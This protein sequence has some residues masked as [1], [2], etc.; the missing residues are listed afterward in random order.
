M[1]LRGPKCWAFAFIQDVCST[2]TFL[3]SP[4]FQLPLNLSFI[5][6]FFLCSE[7]S[8]ERPR[9]NTLLLCKMWTMC[10]NYLLGVQLQ[11]P[12]EG[13]A[14]PRGRR[15]LSRFFF[16]LVFPKAKPRRCVCNG[17]FYWLLAGRVFLFCFFQSK[18]FA[19]CFCANTPQASA[20]K[21]LNLRSPARKQLSFNK[22]KK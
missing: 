10:G 3:S 5:F 1:A 6:F 19:I 14:E 11:A 20:G 12:G 21:G 4:D 8:N 17:A 22:N 18:A 13:L 9:G 7:C 15:R 2:E 16:S